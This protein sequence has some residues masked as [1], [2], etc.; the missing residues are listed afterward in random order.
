MMNRNQ[1]T[2][3]ELNIRRAIISRMAW[4]LSNL[5]IPNI[6]TSSC[7]LKSNNITWCSVKNSLKK[8]EKGLNVSVHADRQTCFQPSLSHHTTN[9]AKIQVLLTSIQGQKVKSLFDGKRKVQCVFTKEIRIYK[10]S[11]KANDCQSK[12]IS[13]LNSDDQPQVQN[14]DMWN[15]V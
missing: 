10:T 14:V 15:P 9:K 13:I 2:L 11:L 4:L 6:H 5:I 1:L 7:N 12:L 8:L 3:L